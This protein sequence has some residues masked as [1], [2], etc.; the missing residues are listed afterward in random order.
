M[1]LQGRW[2]IS[3]GE[4]TKCNVTEMEVIVN[5]LRYKLKSYQNEDTKV[6]VEFTVIELTDDLRTVLMK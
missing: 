5:S 6:S 1:S 2:K 3:R 4:K